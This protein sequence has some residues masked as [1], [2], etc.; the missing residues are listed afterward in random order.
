MTNFNRDANIKRSSR[1][2]F[3]VLEIKAR[4]IRQLYSLL[5]SCPNPGCCLACFKISRGPSRGWGFI[6]S[7]TKWAHASGRWH[8][9][10]TSISPVIT[11]GIFPR[12]V[13]EFEIDT[14]WDRTGWTFPNK[15]P[16]ESWTRFS[17]STFTRN[18]IGS[19]L[20]KTISFYA[21]GLTP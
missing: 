7:S 10:A 3:H 2:L 12:Y 20:W 17:Q 1:I 21:A 6:V 19:R 9:P 13:S 14:A 18:G 4:N 5:G 16:S 11:K 15:D 8:S